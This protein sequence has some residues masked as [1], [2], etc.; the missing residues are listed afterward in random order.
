MEK[1]KKYKAAVLGAGSWGLTLGNVLYENGNS[2]TFW[3]FDP[4]QAENLRRTREFSP[5]KGYKI[6]AE[7]K[8]TDSV[9]DA[10]KDADIIV[11]SV[12]SVA[13][14]STAELLKNAEFKEDAIIVSTVKGFEASTLSSPTQVLEQKLSGRG[15]IGVLSGPSHA[16]EVVNRI[17]TAIVA[18]SPDMETRCTIQKQFSNIYFRV[19]TSS[20]LRGVEL[21]G[22][23]K[24]VIAVASGIAAGAG[25]GDNTRAAL[26]TRGNTEITR[27]GTAMGA[28]RETFSGL[29]GIGDLIVTCFSEHSRNFKFGK[30]LGSGLSFED[31]LS[32]ME[33]TVEGV[34]T[35]RCVDRLAKKYDVS[36]PLCHKVCE[37][38]F[39]SK[40]ASEAWKELMLRPLK[41][42]EHGKCLEEE[43][44]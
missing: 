41:S 4:G 18:A 13:I 39:D 34:N 23:L 8:I 16:E 32:K 11:V 25:L 3:E 27:L 24:N 12:P 28:S 40:P 30:Y 42:E 19:Y 1:K 15:R 37:M 38:L 17:P 44:E 5:L 21:G 9:G 33:T 2:V 22:A 31:A 36:M 6:P 14:E 7:I 20:D 35:A 43:F 29:S 26:I 10:V